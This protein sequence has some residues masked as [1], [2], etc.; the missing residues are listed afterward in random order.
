MDSWG[1]CSG[2]CYSDEDRVNESI[3]YV[4]LARRNVKVLEDRQCQ[5]HCSKNYSEINFVKV[6]CVTNNDDQENKHIV[7]E[8]ESDQLGG[9]L[10]T[11][12]GNELILRGN[13]PYLHLKLIN[14]KG[15]SS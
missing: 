4:S 12:E 9:P 5:R 3:N 13:S 8:E 1:F 7:D 10:Y 6:F 14:K 15:S 2:N 11:K